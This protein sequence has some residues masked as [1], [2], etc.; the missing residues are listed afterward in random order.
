MFACTALYRS[1]YIACS[2]FG[3]LTV[4]TLESKVEEHERQIDKLQRAL[5]RSDT[6]I[7]EMEAEL[8][9]SKHG[10]DATQIQLCAGCQLKFGGGAVTKHR[11]PPTQRGD[12]DSDF[13]LS[14]VEDTSTVDELPSKISAVSDLNLDSRMEE[15]ATFDRH[16]EKSSLNLE[17]PSSLSPSPPDSPGTKVQDRYIPQSAATMMQTSDRFLA[18][19]ATNTRH[20]SGRYL[21]QAT[22]SVTQV[23]HHHIS[24]PGSDAKVS[25]LYS[26]Q[27]DSGS[28]PSEE[29]TR[30]GIKKRL[31]FSN[32]VSR[33]SGTQPNLT[34]P[35]PGSSATV[36]MA[37][38][39]L[40]ISMT[41]EME[42]CFR[43]MDEAKRKVE[44]R[45]HSVPVSGSIPDP[46]E[47]TSQAVAMAT[48]LTVPAPR[49]LGVP[50]PAVSGGS[51]VAGDGSGTWL[52]GGGGQGTGHPGNQDH[53]LFSQ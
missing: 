3:R 49:S 11:K 47:V 50:S 15:S 46:R 51:S 9:K 42:D 16:G 40:N 14:K 27:T 4:A 24:Q 2:R 26:A 52:L 5:E 35:Q 36:T 32:D 19:P 1:I 33:S 12:G 53:R 34:Y 20:V 43:I 21:T 13:T 28:Q 41:P 18:Q 31:R 23:S 29:L 6:Y 17:L 30:E 7:E 25:G 38:T 39:D 48:T 8:E 44:R 22:R 10:S 37:S 45:G